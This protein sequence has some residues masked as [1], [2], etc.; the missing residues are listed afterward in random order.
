MKQENTPLGA[1]LKLKVTLTELG[2]GVHL[3][4]C[5]YS[6]DFTAGSKSKTFTVNGESRSLG[7]TVIDEDTV[8]VALDTGE[9]DTGDL[10]LKATVIV[11][12]ADFPSNARTEIVHHNLHRSIV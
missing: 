1:G 12:D 5:S 7:I 10:Y 9:L 11:P 3:Q 2:E 6:L 8:A 4:D